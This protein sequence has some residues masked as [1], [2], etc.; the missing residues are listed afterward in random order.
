[1]WREIDKCTHADRRCC[2]LRTHSEI[3]ML[4]VR[5]STPLAK[6]GD[7]P[8]ASAANARDRRSACACAPILPPSSI[9]KGTNTCGPPCAAE[10]GW[11]DTLS[12]LSFLSS[13]CFAANPGTVAAFSSAVFLYT[14]V[15]TASIMR[16]RPSAKKSRATTSPGLELSAACKPLASVTIA[17]S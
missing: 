2:H 13:A 14:V 9:A 5:L 1:M 15:M 17:A 8:L 11:L 3:C 16:C 4:C 12:A 7:L 6:G 10:M